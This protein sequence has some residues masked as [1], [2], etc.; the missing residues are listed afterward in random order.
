MGKDLLSADDAVDALVHAERLRV[1]RVVGRVPAQRIDIEHIDQRT[2]IAHAL[3]ERAPRRVRLVPAA[4]AEHDHLVPHE[5]AGVSPARGGGPRRLQLR[6]LERRQ[7]EHVRVRPA[8]ACALRGDPAVQEDVERGPVACGCDYCAETA[9]VDR[10]EAGCALRVP[11][12]AGDVVDVD[13][14]EGFLCVY[15]CCEPLCGG[16]YIYI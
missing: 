1:V 14:V 10:H 5:V 12:L 13:F 11:F 7:R 15:I 9:A 4:A 8:A 3:R 16:I 2:R 6:P